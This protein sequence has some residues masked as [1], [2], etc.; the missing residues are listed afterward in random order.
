MGEK[1]VSNFNSMKDDFHILKLKEQINKK[2]KTAYD[3]L[4][5][6][7]IAT[8]RKNLAWAELAARII[9]KNKKPPGT[10]KWAVITGLVSVMVVSL[11]FIIRLP[12]INIA[13]DIE[14][15]T[16]AFKLKDEWIVQN[17][18]SLS[19]L[20]I[21]N[22]EEVYAAGANIKVVKEQPYN[23][24]FK[25]NNIVMDKLMFS[26]GTDIT[27]QL[28]D[29]TQDLIIKNDT[30]VT[31]IQIGRADLNLNDGELDT[32]VDFEIPET[33]N[34]RS[35]PA[36]AIPTDITLIDTATWNFRDMVVSRI[37]FLEERTPGS[38]K[39]VSSILS[40]NI[41]IL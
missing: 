26:P 1:P 10:V 3:A 37:D 14:T 22:I 30:L 19:E 17:R 23:L 13:A 8:A 24:H 41:K 25:G 4:A 39:F 32:A 5:N 35:F 33:F 21:T 29:S 40:G 7:D 6:D 9:S 2:I 38:G 36:V 15:K 27:I 16:V 18:F 31:A 12:A 28:Q 20:N 11:G 34:I